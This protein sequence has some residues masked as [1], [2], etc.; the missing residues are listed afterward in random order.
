[1]NYKN[2]ISNNYYNFLFNEIQIKYIFHL[3][4]LSSISLIM[5][6]KTPG[7]ILNFFRMFFFNS[8]EKRNK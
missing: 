6:M 8:K 4:Y 7:E 3:L 2:V 1:M 5:M